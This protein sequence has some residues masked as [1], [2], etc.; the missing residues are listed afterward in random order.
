MLVDVNDL[1]TSLNTGATYF[2]E[3]E[4]I[5]PHEGTWCQSH[6]DQCNMYNNA[7]YRPYGV[8]GINQPFSFTGAG[9]TVREQPAIMAWTGATVNQSRTRIRN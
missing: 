4:Y 3:A 7:S 6:P 5:V 9:P 1:N 8:T 2:A